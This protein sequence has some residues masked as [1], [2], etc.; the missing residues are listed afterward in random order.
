MYEETKVDAADWVALGAS[1]MPEQI[2]HFASSHGFAFTNAA[3]F[4]RDVAPGL[5]QFAAA[6]PSF[7]QWG[8]LV[9]EQVIA[10]TSLPELF[11]QSLGLYD[12]LF[13]I[14]GISTAFGLVS[15][16]AMQLKVAE[17]D[18][19]RRLRTRKGAAATYQRSAP[20]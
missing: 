3:E 9:R 15:G 11:V 18:R 14:L 16:R 13:A 8:V 12:V 2:E 6:R 10:Q 7:E 1:P 17:R 19:L 4:L 20:E 5:E